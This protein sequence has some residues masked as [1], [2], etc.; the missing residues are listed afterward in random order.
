MVSLYTVILHLSLYKQR[1]DY[2]GNEEWCT[3]KQGGK[4]DRPRRDN[5]KGGSGLSKVI[6]KFHHNQYPCVIQ[7]KYLIIKRQESKPLNAII[8]RL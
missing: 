5:T 1:K 2:I 3:C 6:S 8:T 4:R 7:Y